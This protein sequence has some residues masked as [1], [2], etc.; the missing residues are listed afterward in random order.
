MTDP[1]QLKA[2]IAQTR[3]DFAETVDELTLR[4]DPREQAKAAARVGSE[5]VR[6]HR[7][8]LAIAAG[9]F[10]LAL[11]GRAIARRQTSRRK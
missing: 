9:L 1:E 11:V 5:A 10:S 7:T 2:E 3:S 8:Q 4:I 6:T